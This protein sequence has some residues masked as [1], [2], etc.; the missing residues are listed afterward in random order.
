M[1]ISKSQI[2]VLTNRALNEQGIPAA[3]TSIEWLGVR[4]KD[5]HGPLY[6][7]TARVRLEGSISISKIATL[8]NDGSFRIA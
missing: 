1:K 3:I 4:T 2:R 5:R 7:R 8:W 6:G